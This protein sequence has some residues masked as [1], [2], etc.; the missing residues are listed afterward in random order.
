[1]KRK[2]LI[3]LSLVIIMALSALALCSCSIK[4]LYSRFGDFRYTVSDEKVTITRY[5]GKET[6]LTV[7]ESIKGMPVVA[8]ANDAFEGCSTLMSV[9]IPDSVE[10]I[11]FLAFYTWYIWWFH[12]MS[13]HPLTFLSS[14][15]G[16]SLPSS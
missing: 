7:P 1:M 4:N 10:R 12:S 2:S 15:G 9:T 8:I 13:T 16:A 11:G 5:S 14:R 3:F 6:H